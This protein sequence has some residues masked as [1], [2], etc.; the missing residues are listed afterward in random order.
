M[1]KQLPTLNLHETATAVAACCYANRVPLVLG[2]PGVA[3]TTLM[4]TMAPV[5]GAAIGVPD[6][7]AEICILSNREAVDVGGYPMV[8]DGEVSLKLFGSLRHAAEAPK[9]LVLDE[10]LTCSQSV[11]GPA[12]RLVLEG[13]AGETPLHAQTRV[14]C[15]ANDPEQAPGGIQMTAAL[16]NRLVILRCCP[17]IGE[18]AAFFCHKASTDLTTNLVLPDAD[19]WAERKARLMDTVGILMEARPDMVCFTPPPASIND[20]EPFA[21]PR[22]WEICC[23]VLAALPP[24]DVMHA[25]PVVKAVVLGSVGLGA[26]LAFLSMIRARHHLPT[27]KEVLANPKTAKLPDESIEIVTDNGKE[28]RPIGRDVTFA[29]IP[30]VVE[31]ARVDTFAAWLYAVRL[32]TEIQAALAKGLSTQMIAPASSPWR[33]EGQQVMIE[34][35]GRMTGVQV[36]ARKAG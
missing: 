6:L 25:T 23:D 35:I 21:S 19:E 33:K 5:I 3:K 7:A 2:S 13:V 29:S 36:V 27:V 22:A 20:G 10:F 32:P 1:T 17:T 8:Y 4:R 15:A 18:V 14:A 30:L 16:V 26:G 11:Q 24:D 12:M 28:R 34:T 9:L 31:A